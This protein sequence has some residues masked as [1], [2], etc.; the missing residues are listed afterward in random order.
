VYVKLVIEINSYT[1]HGTYNIKKK[2]PCS[3]HGMKF[4]TKK[5]VQNYGNSFIKAIFT[6][7]LKNK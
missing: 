3:L 6:K 7:N 4:H 2:N 1:M 5:A